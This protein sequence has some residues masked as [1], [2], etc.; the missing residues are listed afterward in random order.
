MSC[1]SAATSSRCL[2]STPAVSRTTSGSTTS[3][4]S[5]TSALAHSTLSAMPGTRWKAS[6]KGWL[7]S[8]ATKSA[9]C[10]AS[11]A[12][13]PGTCARDDGELALALGIVEP[14]VQAA[15]LDGV[16]QVA[17]AVAR[18]D[19]H[20]RGLGAD[21]AKL[22]DADL[23]LAEVFEQKGLERLVGPIDL[24]D[25]QQRAGR[26]RLQRL[27]QRAA[28]EVALLIDLALELRGV[29]TA[30]ALGGAHV[31]K[32]RGVVPLVQR[33]ALLE[34]VVAL[35][36]DQ[37]ARQHARERLRKRRLADARLAFEQQRALQP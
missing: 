31:Q 23:V 16:V 1:V 12:L 7:R 25:Q 3:V 6:A 33:L 4:S 37:A 22:R 5:A 8:R 34:A 26:G 13:A 11:A 9:T 14:E 24:V 17:R 28:D 21:G 18:E 29:G 2:K 19:G 36:P 30:A 27:Q 15:A 35:Q 20:G 32:L 10:T